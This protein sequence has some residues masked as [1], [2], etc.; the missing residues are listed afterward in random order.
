MLNRESNHEAYESHLLGENVGLRLDDEADGAELLLRGEQ[1][2]RLVAVFQRWV[3]LR[4]V[5]R[6]VSYIVVYSQYFHLQL[7]SRWSA[8]PR[9]A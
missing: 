1:L 4:S 9:T 6:M 3:S 5:K 7:A 8:H 2:F